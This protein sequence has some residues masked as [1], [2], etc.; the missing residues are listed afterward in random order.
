MDQLKEMGPSGVDTEIRS[1]SPDG[2]GDIQL[3]AQFI[4]F[5]YVILQTNRDFELVQSYLAL[6][7]KVFR[8]LYRIIMFL[9]SNN[10][11][12]RQTRGT[13]TMLF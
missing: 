5:T 11:G 1:L 6:F 8:P 10:I 7:L 9:Y 12:T 2:G 4:K 3:M 13:D